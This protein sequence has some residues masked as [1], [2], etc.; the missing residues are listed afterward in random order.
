MTIWLRGE[1]ANAAE[2]LYV[3]LN[4]S[5]VVNNDN[6]DAAQATAWTQWNIDLQAFADQ[7]VNLA[8]VTSITLGL[9]N[10]NNPVAGGAG[11]M[12]FDDILLYPPA[13]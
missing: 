11:M 12:Y 2:N 5:A 1:S 10:R 6:P 13:P 8:N 4:D 3:V 9:G 7:G